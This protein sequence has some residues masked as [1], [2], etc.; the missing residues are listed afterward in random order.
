MFIL[1]CLSDVS[2]AEF[3]ASPQVFVPEAEKEA[4][5]ICRLGNDSQIAAEAL[6]SVMK[7]G[8]VKDLVGGL[9]AWAADI[10]PNFPV[11]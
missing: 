10:D 4:Y 9:R 2:L 6:R 3:V 11:Y 7:D 8:T 1:S 5:L